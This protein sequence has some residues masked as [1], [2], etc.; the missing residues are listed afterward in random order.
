M[1]LWKN[2]FFFKGIDMFKEKQQK[3]TGNMV[4]LFGE[5]K[6]FPGIQVSSTDLYM[7]VVK[8]FG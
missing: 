3:C 6:L 8:A 4:Y 5:W 1:F 2:F 7:S